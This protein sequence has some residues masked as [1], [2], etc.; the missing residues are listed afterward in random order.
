MSVLSPPPLYHL[1]SWWWHRHLWQP[2][3]YNIKA[4]SGHHNCSN[5]TAG[6]GHHTLT[7]SKQDHDNNTKHQLH[8]IKTP[9]AQVEQ[10]LTAT[11]TMSDAR[12]H[13]VQ[14]QV[15]ICTVHSDYYKYLY[16]YLIK[17]TRTGRKEKSQSKDCMI[18]CYI[19]SVIFLRKQLFKYIHIHDVES[20][21]E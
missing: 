4:G 11:L 8:K 13:H 7:K 17:D 12:T 9:N 10:G 3:T 15:R 16:L 2:Y 1:T 21:T 14:E 6:P 20:T 18:T 19:S 5:T